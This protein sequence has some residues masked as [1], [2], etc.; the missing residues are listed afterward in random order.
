[1]EGDCVLV[2]KILTLAN[3]RLEAD[4]VAIRN[5]RITYAGTAR[6]A[7]HNVGPRA[8]VIDLAGRVALP[9]FI[10]SHSHPVLLGR[11]LEEVDCR[12]C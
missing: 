11:Y 2:G 10:E 9:G 7:R 1:M 8:E 4:A 3:S 5:G 12:Y 6:E